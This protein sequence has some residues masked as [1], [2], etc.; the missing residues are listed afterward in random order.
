M[1]ADRTANDTPHV[2]NV[3]EERAHLVLM[4]A[5]MNNG[6]RTTDPDTPE[7]PTLIVINTAVGQ[8]SWHIHPDHAHLFADVPE[9]RRDDPRAAWDGHTTDEKY[10]RARTIAGLYLTAGRAARRITPQGAER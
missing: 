2:R 8:M 9:V 10:T 7:C 1:I 3:Y 6:V 5:A 4:L